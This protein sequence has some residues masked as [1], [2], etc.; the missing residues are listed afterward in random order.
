MDYGTANT[1]IAKLR[2]WCH[3]VLPAVYDDS[4]TYYELLCKIT[5]KINEII[6]KDD[7][8]TDA[9]LELKA[10]LDE[11][12]EQF[13]EFQ[14]QGFQEYY[15]EILS[16]WVDENLPGIIAQSA[17]MVFFG[18]T[19]DGYFVAYIPD[20]LDDLIFDTGMQYG[21]DTYGRLILRW[22]VDDSADRVNQRPEDWS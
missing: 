18:L 1:G 12:K 2:Y 5:E 20:A 6:A 11:L 7:D 9:I 19:L 13:E 3:K 21:I 16:A 8:A 17:K 15:E 14:E 10:E 4:L 22:D